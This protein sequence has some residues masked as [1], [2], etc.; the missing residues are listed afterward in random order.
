MHAFARALLSR[1]IK[2]THLRILLLLSV[3]FSTPIFEERGNSQNRIA[4]NIDCHRS[5]S[6]SHTAAAQIYGYIFTLGSNF[7]KGLI[8]K[9]IV[10]INISGSKHPFHQS[11]G[12]IYKVSILRS[13][14]PC[15]VQYTEHITK[16]VIFTHL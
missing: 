6:S 14:K 13:V 7:M 15:N 16:Q 10:S 1:G 5:S 8:K 3:F 12:E 4:N 9:L 11:Q 2:L